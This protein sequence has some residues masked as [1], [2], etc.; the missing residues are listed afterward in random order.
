M[1]A[2]PTELLAP[3]HPLDIPTTTPTR[4]MIE[5]FFEGADL[6]V[7]VG[8]FAT[9]GDS[10]GFL[11]T[12]G[13]EPE[14]GFLGNAGE[15]SADLAGLGGVSGGAPFVEAASVRAED[16]QLFDTNLTGLHSHSLT[17]HYI[18]LYPYNT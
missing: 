14:E 10:V 6:G 5:G 12:L 11:G 2:T 16:V 7:D 1:Q 17:D 4:S 9:F 15:L 3:P 8:F 13:G 18:G